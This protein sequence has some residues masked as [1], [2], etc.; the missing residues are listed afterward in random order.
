[1][2]NLDVRRLPYQIFVDILTR[3]DNGQPFACAVEFAAHGRPS[4]RNGM[5]DGP[6]FRRDNKNP[7]WVQHE[8]K[9]DE[10]FIK[11]PNRLT[12]MQQLA[13]NIASACPPQNN[14]VPAGEKVLLIGNRDTL[15]LL[16]CYCAPEHLDHRVIPLTRDRVLD[17]L[18]YDADKMPPGKV[19]NSLGDQAYHPSD[20]ASVVR[21]TRDT[22]SM[23]MGRTI[24]LYDWRKKDAVAV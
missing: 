13:L 1:M 8:K 19:A 11:L 2:A 24:Q 22:V 20:P 9:F 5:I 21:L 14:L 17:L 12:M 10:K 23:A 3:E 16:D 7:Q 4:F 6:A 18:G 15:S